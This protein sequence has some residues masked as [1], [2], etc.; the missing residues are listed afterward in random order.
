VRYV[1]I[2]RNITQTLLYKDLVTTKHYK[3]KSSSKAWHIFRF[4]LP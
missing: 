2:L 1:V 4:N 3:D